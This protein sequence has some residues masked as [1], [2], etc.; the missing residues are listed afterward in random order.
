MLEIFYTSILSSLFI[1]YVMIGIFSWKLESDVNQAIIKVI[2]SSKNLRK[3]KELLVLTK[4]KK[5]VFRYIFWPIA[6][7]K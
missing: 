6:F 1:S 5:S 4:V 7:L 2:S 3:Q